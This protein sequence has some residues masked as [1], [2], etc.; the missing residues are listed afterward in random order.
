MWAPKFAA[1]FESIWLY[2]RGRVFPR[3]RGWIFPLFL[4]V[5]G[6]RGFSEWMGDINK[7]NA[8]GRM[9]EQIRLKVCPTESRS[10]PRDTKCSRV[11]CL[12]CAAFTGSLL[13]SGFK[14]SVHFFAW[15][16]TAD[17]SHLSLLRWTALTLTFPGRVCIT[18]DH[19]LISGETR[20]WGSQASSLQKQC[21]KK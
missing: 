15:N 14:D 8:K 17:T 20:K 21:Y 9:L 7:G 12:L 16:K 4:W 1:E 11:N 13:W 2:R 3:N 5:Q 10:V 19:F 6:G 18:I